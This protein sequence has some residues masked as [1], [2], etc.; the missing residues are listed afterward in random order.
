[1][2]VVDANVIAYLL[3]PGQHTAAAE[4]LLLQDQD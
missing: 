4:K 2:I 1:V 3:I